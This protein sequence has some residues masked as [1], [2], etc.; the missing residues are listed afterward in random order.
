VE[1]A[2]PRKKLH[3]KDNQTFVVVTLRNIVTDPQFRAGYRSRLAGRPPHRFYFDPNVKGSRDREW[4]Y[5]RGRL[6]ASWALA[7]GQTPPPLSDVAGLVR[8]YQAA[9][10]ADVIL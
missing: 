4:G 8:A 3:R 5:E 2:V 9:E 10:N 1:I 6:V 7:S